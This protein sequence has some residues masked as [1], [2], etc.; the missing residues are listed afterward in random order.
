MPYSEE[1]VSG[2]ALR[3]CT[4]HIGPRPAEF[5]VHGVAGTSIG[6]DDAMLG[7]HVLYL[8]GIGTG[9][10]VGISAL[11][12][13]VR[14]SMTA[15]DVMVVF[16]TKGDY[17]ETFHRPG[18]AVIAAT[19]AD[20]FAGQVSWNLFE[21]FRALP[22]GRLPEDEIFEMCSGLS[23]RL[24][25]DA[26]DNAY[27]ANA[28]RDV[29]TALVTAMYRESEER[30]NRDIRMIVGGM[31][32]GEMHALLDRPGNADLR[33]A[34]HYIAKEGSNSTM[35]TMAFM[36]QVIQESFRS[37]FGRPGDFSIRA[38]LRAKGARALF[39]E[40][41]IASGSTL[42][43]VFTTMLDVAMKEAMSRRRAAGRVF[44]VLDEFALLP[45]LTHLSD[46]VN[47]GRSLGLRFIVGTQNVKQVQEMYGPEMAA[48]VLSAFGSVFAFRLYDGDSRRFVGDR[49]GANRKLTRFDAAVR[50]SGLREEVITGAMVEDWDLSSLGVGTCVAALPDGPPVRFRFAP[51]SSSSSPPSPTSR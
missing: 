30:S 50:G 35:A 39:L 17:H 40:Y 18:D 3:D 28:A 16:D 1:V 33:G 47:F 36:Q 8:G 23:S 6:F 49:F 26:G 9:K 46:G 34:R 45:E 7:R 2:T 51:P 14:A 42:A 21:E 20:E 43:P 32:I 12:A 27:F 37:S 38:F 10:T 24:I 48:S 25:A 29:F 19:L 31:G 41:D 11:V 44:F 4:G 5:G 15:D 13:S 22:P